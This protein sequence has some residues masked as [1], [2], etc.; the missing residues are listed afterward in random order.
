MQ[1]HLESL[2]VS[3]ESIRALGQAFTRLDARRGSGEG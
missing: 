2:G 1:R 3:P